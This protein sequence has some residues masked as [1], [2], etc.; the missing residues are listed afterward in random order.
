MRALRFVTA[1]A[2]IVALFGAWPS[3]ASARVTFGE[4][5]TWN[6]TCTQTAGREW[7]TGDVLHFRNQT[8][9]AMIYEIETGLISSSHLISSGDIN[10]SNGNGIVY[11]TFVNRPI[12]LAATMQGHYV[13]GLR[14]WDVTV[15][16]FGQGTG[17]LAGLT[18]RGLGKPVEIDLVPAHVRQLCPGG[19]VLDGTYF[20]T[21]TMQHDR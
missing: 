3:Q 8:A 1:L 2:L 18:T 13:V 6:V 21:R 17:E 7:T 14:G 20:T 4:I 9:E 10:L 12:S 16:S 19:I 5:H 15:R 11:G